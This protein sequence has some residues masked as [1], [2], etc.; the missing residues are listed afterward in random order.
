MLKVNRRIVLITGGIR[1]GKSRFAQQLANS[2]NKQ[3]LYIATAEA[4]DKE[5]EERILL[6]KQN[7]PTSWLVEEEPIEIAK[8]LSLRTALDKNITSSLDIVVLID[9]ITIW[10]SNLLLQKDNNGKEFWQTKQGLK[11]VEKTI[12]QFLYQLN[13]IPYP[14][15]A[16]TNEV[17][18]GGIEINPL[19]RKYQDILGWTNQK[20]AALAN[21]AYFVV[22]GI[23]LQIKNNDEINS[24]KVG[25]NHD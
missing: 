5:M 13:K 9:C 24:L 23:P 17:G 6:H 7:R 15:I 16:V 22:A 10:V 19:G 25:T 14:V 11:A 12:E 4:K 3:V 21:E 18:W 2:L 1:S 8:L 20:I